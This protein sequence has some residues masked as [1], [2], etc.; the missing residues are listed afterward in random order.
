MLGVFIEFETNLRRDRQTEGI[1][2]SEEDKASTK[3]G[4]GPSAKIKA[5]I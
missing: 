2:G 3:G 5:P 1:A 4:R